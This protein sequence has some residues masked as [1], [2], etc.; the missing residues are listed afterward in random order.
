VKRVTFAVPGDLATPTGGYAYDRRVILELRAL[1]WSVDVL[2]IGTG[3][4]RP[5]DRIRAQAGALLQAVPHGQPIVAD[6]L[7]YGVLA[8]EAKILCRNHPIVALVHHPLA[9][10]TGLSATQAAALQASERAALACAKRVVTTSART[11]RLVREQFDVA[12][13]RITVVEPGTDRVTVDR[14]TSAECISL[15]AVGA[16]V[17]RKGYDVLLAALAQIR[18]RT[19][20][21]TVI[22]DRTRS[23]DTVR[24]LDD[25]VVKLNL[26]DRVKF[27]GAISCAEL[28]NF[29]ASADVF[30]LPSRFE[31]Y[32]M[33]FAE[34][35]AYG[36]PVVATNAGAIPD[37]VPA[38]AGILV[39]PDDAGALAQ[40]LRRLIES[41]HERE[42]LAAGARA[43]AR[44][45]P[46]WRD[47]ATLFA[48]VLDGIVDEK[49]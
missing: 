20:H 35:L 18:D 10:E 44:S 46:S 36:L 9:L 42:N 1:G 45:L 34:A 13:D 28:A 5:T 6:G 3:F 4:P 33:A 24:C 30:V 47:S 25:E 39:A 37:T 31:G 38:T 48:H 23:P 11:A 41:E 17:P 22:G 27:I 49:Q 8:E 40:A 16:V 21:L 32:G 2:D 26:A 14:R 7:A 43:A 15:L 19:W 29:Y 12:A